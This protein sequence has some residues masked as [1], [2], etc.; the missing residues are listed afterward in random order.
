MTH[1]GDSPRFLRLVGCIIS[2]AKQLGQLPEV[3]ALKVDLSEFA[4]P[5]RC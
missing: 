1:F 2:A 5:F 4:G 3:Y